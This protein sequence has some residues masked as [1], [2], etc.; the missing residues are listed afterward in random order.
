MKSD[1]WWNTNLPT[2]LDD[3]E[4]W[5]GGAMNETRLPV[6]KTIKD[7]GYQTVLD[8]G[9][10][11]CAEYDGFKL[12][13]SNIKYEAL[14]TCKHLIEMAKTKGINATL[15]SIEQI[16]F[17][18]N[19]FEIVICRGVIEHLED[20]RKPISEMVRVA[21][22][23]V[24]ISWFLAPSKFEVE[25]KTNMI[26]GGALLLHNRYVRKDIQSYIDGIGQ[27]KVT[28]TPLPLDF[29]MLRIIK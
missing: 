2:R 6:R 22:K 16:P 11:L 29:E 4:N 23:E 7:A 17:P 1:D 20:F 5:L 3:F 19:A 15:G 18:N 9:A 14:D 12:E 28:W 10:G 27:F 25:E 13:G 21:S 24:L 26:E 8:C